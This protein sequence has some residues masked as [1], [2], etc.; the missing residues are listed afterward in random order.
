LRA[1]QGGNYDLAR[2][3]FDAFQRLYPK[4][5]LADQ[6]QYYLADSYHHQ[7][8]LRQAIAGYDKLLRNFP[9]SDIVP[10]AQLRKV[11]ALVQSGE[12]V[13]GVRE[14]RALIARY[15]NS[16]EA[17]QAQQL[18]QRFEW[19]QQADSNLGL[20]VRELNPQ[21]ARRL[22]LS[23]T[24]GGLLVRQVEPGSFAQKLGL[25]RG[26]IITAVNGRSVR[27]QQALMEMQR[28]LTPGREVVVRIK[29]RQRGRGTREL[30]LRGTP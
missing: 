10:R 20:Q 27:S 11:K 12:R 13:A 16:E 23:S 4:S 14:L 26:D 15:P 2:R 1:F 25:R 24:E 19:F 17:R 7:Q 18:L 22:G 3:Q 28:S 9:A 29:R 6:A 21:M 8:D 30:T 5:E